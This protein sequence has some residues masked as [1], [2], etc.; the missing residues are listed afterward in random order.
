MPNQK[1]KIVYSLR[2]H[3]ALQQQGFAHITEMKNPQNP[4]LNCW[5]YAVTPDFMTAFEALMGEVRAND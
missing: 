2:I 4:H 3:V 5:V 1:V